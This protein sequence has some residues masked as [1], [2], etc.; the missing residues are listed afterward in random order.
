MPVSLVVAFGL[1]VTEWVTPAPLDWLLFAIA[2]ICG[3]AVHY[4]V[5]FAY[6][7]TR[8]ATIA[9][10]EYTGLLWAAVLGFVFWQEIPT[11]WTLAGAF[12]IIGGGLMVLREPA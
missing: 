2:G 6:S 3:A 8:A 1:T 7:H 10:M 12:V 5:V 11:L 9:P 4:C